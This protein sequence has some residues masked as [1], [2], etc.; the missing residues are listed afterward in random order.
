MQGYILSK[1][2]YLFEKESEN[3]QLFYINLCL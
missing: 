2:K 1:M 3:L